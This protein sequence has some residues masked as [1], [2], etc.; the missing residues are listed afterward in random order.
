MGERIPH[1]EAIAWFTPLYHAVR[2]VR[3]LCA[4][5]MGAEA[6]SSAAWITIGCAVLLLLVPRAMRKRVVK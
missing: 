4:G 1:G 3:G 2:L 5:E 6:W